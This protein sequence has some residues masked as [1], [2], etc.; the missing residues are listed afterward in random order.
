[1]E[2]NVTIG[3]HSIDNDNNKRNGLQTMHQMPPRIFKTIIF[4]TLCVRSVAN[5]CT[6]YQELSWNQLPAT[7]LSTPESWRENAEWKTHGNKRW[8]K[9]DHI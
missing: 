9:A 1:M 4:V 2:I 5:G 3:A 7:A 8:S 6:T